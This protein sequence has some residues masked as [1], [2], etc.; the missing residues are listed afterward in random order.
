MHLIPAIDL[1][2]G[3][4]VRLTQGD[5]SSVKK[6]DGKPIDIAK[7][8]EAAGLTHLHLV[9]LDGAKQRRIVNYKVLE[10]I[11]TQTSLHVDF[12]GGLRTDEDLRIAFECGAK[13]VTGGSIAI[14]NPERFM[15]WIQQYGGDKIIL[16]ADAKD[17]MIAISGW[18]E[19]SDQTLENVVSEYVT[20][21][22]R[23]VISTDI[24]KD[25]MLAGPSVDMYRSLKSVFSVVNIIASGGITTLK[26]LTELKE[27]GCYGAIIGKAIYENKLTL[28]QLTNWSLQQVG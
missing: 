24:A 19:T 20:A 25:G 28:E 22:I 14:R 26:D 1:I 21:G 5:Y 9:D 8:Y 18:E 7:R 10:E 6:Y 27:A 23:Y 12:G 13:Q 2:G 17:G 11:T 15:S 4:C 16:G 3:R